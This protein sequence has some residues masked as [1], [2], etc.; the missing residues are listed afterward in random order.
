MTRMISIGRVDRSKVTEN[1]KT[2]HNERFG[3]YA[4]IDGAFD[5]PEDKN[6]MAIVLNVTDLEGLRKASRTPE[7]DAFMRKGGFVEQLDYYLE[8][9]L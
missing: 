7:G 8:G 3:Q 1:W 2:E 4:T 6:Q 5:H 9:T